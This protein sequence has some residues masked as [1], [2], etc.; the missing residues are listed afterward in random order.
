MNNRYQARQGFA[1]WWVFD[2]DNDR[3]IAMCSKESEARMIE[4]ALNKQEGE[5]RN[6]RHTENRRGIH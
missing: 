1:Q 3:I 4:A 6:E 5:T 2:N